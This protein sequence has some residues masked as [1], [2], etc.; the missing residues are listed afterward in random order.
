[1]LHTIKKIKIT[2]TYSF[3]FQHV[4]VVTQKNEKT[5]KYTNLDIKVGIRAI[6]VIV[7]LF[8]KVCLGNIFY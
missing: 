4:K 5:S 2:P 3:T 6:G 1:M 7:L 8:L